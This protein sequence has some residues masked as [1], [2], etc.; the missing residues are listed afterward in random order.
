MPTLFITGANRGLGLEFTRRYV[1][2]GWQ[3]IA[4]CR[5]PQGASELR[6][7][8]VEIVALDMAA[9]DRV[10]DAAALV[11]D[12]PLDLV[13]A[14]AGMSGPSDLTKPGAGEAFE[15]VLT[16]NTVAPTLLALALA[17]NVERTGGKMI[18][19]SSVMGSIAENGAG[20]STAYRASKAA[21]NAAWRSVSIDLKSRDLTMA[22]LHP[23]WVRT[24][25]GGPN[26][27]ISVEESIAGMRET[28]AGLK[29]TQSGGFFNYTGEPLAW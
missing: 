27:S 1:E 3:V 6:A 25:M 14:N 2:D 5:D 7:L 9:L 13:I 15:Q 24:D 29:R 12:R 18:A 26:A 20:G 11:G 22:M 17:D 10:A 28:I 16:V 23:G 21:L 19:I 8:G 4:A